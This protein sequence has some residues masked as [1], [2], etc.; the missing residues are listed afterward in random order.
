MKTVYIAHPLLSDHPNDI[1]RVRENMW[2]IDKIC[3]KIANEEHDVL[4]LSPIHAFMFL[5]W[6]EE[7]SDARARELCMHLVALANEVRIYGDYESSTGCQAEIE[8]A[9]EL[10]LPIVYEGGHIEG[11]SNDGE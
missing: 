10:C 1:E 11:G 3:R 6:E 8:R 5:P 9:R 4:P 7:E 2:K